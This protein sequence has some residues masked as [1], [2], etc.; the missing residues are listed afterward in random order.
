MN[1]RE[2]N[3]LHAERLRAAGMKATAPRLAIL[4]F[5]ETDRT[6]PSAERIHEEI[7]A[8]LPSL[9][10]S[11]VYSTLEAFLD[12]GLV[13]RIQTPEGV[14]RVDGTVQDHDHAICRRCGAVFDVPRESAVRPLGTDA[15]P[16]GVR[17]VGVHIEYEVECSACR[18]AR[19][20]DGV[21]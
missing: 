17:L 13:R 11:T 7:G 19:T 2:S 8:E 15:L 4:S 14:L 1:K 21:A 12:A 18:G 6:H 9:S 10:L 5:L 20:P 3:Q 16:E